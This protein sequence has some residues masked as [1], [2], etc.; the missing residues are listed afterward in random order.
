M[1]AICFS[2]KGRLFGVKCG[3]IAFLSLKIVGF[4]STLSKIFLC[5]LETC[6]DVKPMKKPQTQAQQEK[7][8]TRVPKKNLFIMNCTKCNKKTF[9]KQKNFFRIYY[10]ITLIKKRAFAEANQ[11]R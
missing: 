8:P 2:L 5:E 9:K 6:S 11:F 4:C 3:V 7:K 10:A 1:S